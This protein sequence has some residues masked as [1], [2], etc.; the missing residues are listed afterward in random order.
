MKGAALISRVENILVF[1]VH[2]QRILNRVRRDLRY[3]GE[4]EL[5]L[6]RRTLELSRIPSKIN[7]RKV[8]VVSCNYVWPNID[9]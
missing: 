6:E 2:D 1:E 7:H 4:I 3:M 8:S 5:N 9:V